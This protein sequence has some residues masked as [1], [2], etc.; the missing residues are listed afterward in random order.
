MPVRDMRCQSL[1]FGGPAAGPGHVGLDPGFVD[2]DQSLGIEPMLVR[3]PSRPEPRDLRAHLLAGHQGLF[4]TVW[5]AR[6]TNR[7]TVSCATSTPRA[8]PTPPSAPASSGRASRPSAPEASFRPHLPERGGGDRQSCPEPARDQSADAGRSARL[9]QQISRTAWPP[10]LPSHPPP[11]RT[12]P[13]TGGPP[14]VVQPSFVP[15][16]W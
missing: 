12:Q 13:A 7:H 2:E 16:I 3:P 4:L 14:K 10:P 9:R 11:T 15:I 6:L 5:P 8:R 1:A